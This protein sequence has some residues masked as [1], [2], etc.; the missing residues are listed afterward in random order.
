[1]ENFPTVMETFLEQ[2]AVEQV[3]SADALSAAIE[4]LLDSPPDRDA[5]GARAQQVVVESR[6][7]MERT[8]E[9]LDGK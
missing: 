2:Q 5:L 3:C 9:R 4:R 7:V 1:M 6:G 8:V